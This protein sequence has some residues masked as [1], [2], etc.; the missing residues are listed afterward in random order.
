M[1]LL[2]S[3]FNPTIPRDTD[4]VAA[5]AAEIRNIKRRLKDFVSVK[6]DPETGQFKS[7]SSNITLS[8]TDPTNPALGDVY[9]NTV[10]L[11]AFVFNSSGWSPILRSA[12]PFA[13]QYFTATGTFT[14]PAG[15]YRLRIHAWGAGG[16]GTGDV[17]GGGGGSGGSGAYCTKL[18]EV[19]PG[20]VVTITIGAGGAAEVGTGGSASNGGST[21]V[22]V[23]A[24]TSVAG[25]GFGSSAAQT[26]VNGGTFSGG[27]WGIQG[28]YGQRA[29]A[30]DTRG[31]TAP[32]GGCGGIGNA[33]AGVL[34]HGKVP[35]G[36]GC[37]G[38]A[39]LNA[40]G[41]GAGG[42]VLIEY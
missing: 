12:L 37:G 14:V 4:P 13:Q 30:N 40:A 31:G 16:G 28:S 5:G 9:F 3:D 41:N 38:L 35:G 10:S 24:S 11:T 33:A 8:S 2:G 34:Q 25:G 6:F 32:L 17:G 29:L 26:S 42:A 22:V 23:G 19:E 27:D 20:D 7:A 39:S 36:G 18:V 21:T 15:V 1:A